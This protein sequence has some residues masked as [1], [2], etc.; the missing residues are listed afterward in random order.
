MFQTGVRH[1]MILDAHLRCA[2]TPGRP[3]SHLVD[4][5]EILGMDGAIFAEEGD[6]GVVGCGAR[7][8]STAMGLLWGMSQKSR[9]SLL[10]PGRKGYISADS[11]PSTCAAHSHRW[12]SRPRRFASRQEHSP[13]STPS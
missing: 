6:F 5:I 9:T 13:S 1:G 7:E 8:P 10:E 3:D 2:W 4:Q 11:P 12:G